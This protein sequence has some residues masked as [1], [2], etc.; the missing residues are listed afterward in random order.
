[1]ASGTLVKGLKKRAVT[2]TVS[3]D[4]NHICET[5]VY[6][7]NVLVSIEIQGY[8]TGAYF[9]YQNQWYCSVCDYNFGK[10]L[11]G[12]YSATVYYM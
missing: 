7:P 8:S 6:L 12:S 5:G 9:V 10:K 2:L 4:S 1:M 3:S 11:S